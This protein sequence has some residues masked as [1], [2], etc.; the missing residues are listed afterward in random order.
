MQALA[1]GQD[2][3]YSG[4]PPE[5]GWIVQP[6]PVHC[7]ASGPSLPEFPTA[8]HVTED[9]QDTLDSSLV[10]APAGLGADWIVQL[11]PFH[12][13]ANGASCGPSL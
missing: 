3:P 5:I 4:A 9:G 2:T 10:Y 7:S 11:V 13:S 6:L 8:K 12:V 1:V